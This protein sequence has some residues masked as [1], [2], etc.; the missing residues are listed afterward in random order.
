MRFALLED[1]DTGRVDSGGDGLGAEGDPGR[2][3][4]DDDE[5]E[6]FAGEAHH[7]G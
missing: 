2:A 7:A 4:A 1:E 3:G 6:E 5:V